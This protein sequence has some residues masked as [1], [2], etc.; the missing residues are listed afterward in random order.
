MLRYS[1]SLCVPLFV[2]SPHRL[3]L[4]VIIASSLPPPSANC[5]DPAPYQHDDGSWSM[6]CDHFPDDFYLATAPHYSGPW[7]IQ[8]A[9]GSTCDLQEAK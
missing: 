9:L 4:S 8:R 2:P 1:C 5:G 7:T 6:V 3:V